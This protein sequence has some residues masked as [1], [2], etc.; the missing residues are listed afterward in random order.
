MQCTG[1]WGCFPGESEQAWYGSICFLLCAVFLCFHTTD[2][3][4][5]LL[6]QMDTGSL[7][8][9]NLG[10]YRTQILEVPNCW[11][12]SCD[13][14]LRTSQ[15]GVL[16]STDCGV[17]LFLNSAGLSCYRFT[18]KTWAS[19]DFCAHYFWKFSKFAGTFTLTTFSFVLCRST[20][21]WIVCIPYPVY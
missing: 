11:L 9:T 3:R 15:T 8:C 16:I 20:L 17:G 5:I 10:T 18:N 4:P 1:N 21:V 7:V 12:L 13:P 2:V 6:R 14:V 19:W